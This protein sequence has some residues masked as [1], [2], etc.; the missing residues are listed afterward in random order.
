LDAPR[1]GRTSCPSDPAVRYEINIDNT[2]DGKA[3]IAYTFRFSTQ[4][5]ATNFAGIP[6]FLYN[7]GQVTSLNDPNLLVK[8]TYDVW[9]N[10]T[11]IADDVP[12]PPANIGPRSTPNYAV[13]AASA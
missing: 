1:R 4:R 10:G 13:L 2:G 9:R 7:D 12:V 5:K 3:D 11:R 8:Q 6:T